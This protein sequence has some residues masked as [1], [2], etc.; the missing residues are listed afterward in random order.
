VLLFAVFVASLTGG[1]RL[2]KSDEENVLLHQLVSL[3][4]HTYRNT[5]AVPDDLRWM[6]TQA[7]L[8]GMS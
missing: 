8:L 3:A 7:S 4:M 6:R 5:E 1:G 2:S